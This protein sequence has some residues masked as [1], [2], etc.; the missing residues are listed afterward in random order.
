M[1]LQIFLKKIGDA[2]ESHLSVPVKTKITAQKLFVYL[3][4]VNVYMYP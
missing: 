1:V 4:S 3:E 2:S